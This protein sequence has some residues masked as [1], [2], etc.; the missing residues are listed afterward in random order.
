MR[1]TVCGQSYGLTHNC[2]GIS[3]AQSADEKAPPSHPIPAV[4]YFLEAWRIARWDDV[5]IRRVAGDKNALLFGVLLWGVGAFAL[6][7]APSVPLIR[8]GVPVNWPA[9]AIGLF[10]GAAIAAAVTMAQYAVCHF[11]A[12]WL[13]HATGTYIGVLRPLL[14]GFS[15]VNWAFLI[16]FVGIFIGGLWGI[17]ILMF[18]FEEVDGIERMQAFGIAFV[19]GIAFQYLLGI[20]IQ[21][22]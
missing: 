22:G 20:L 5:A 17:A 10:V 3:P 1:C 12:K 11:T 8:A 18:V 4:H 15:I 2:A 21:G 9:L 6:V 16:P 7:A 13:F 19:A 14:L